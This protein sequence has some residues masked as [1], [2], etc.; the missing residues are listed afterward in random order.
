MRP[1]NTLFFLS[2]NHA[3]SAMGCS[4]NSVIHTPT[5][6]ALAARGTRFANAYTASPLC[7]PACVVTA[8]RRSAA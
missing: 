4:G 6:D 5:L 7:C 8:T 3:R 2:D 1:A